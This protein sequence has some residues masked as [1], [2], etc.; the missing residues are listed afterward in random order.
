MSSSSLTRKHTDSIVHVYIIVEVN[1]INEFDL[2][3][4]SKLFSEA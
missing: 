4:I 1:K 3:L 2:G